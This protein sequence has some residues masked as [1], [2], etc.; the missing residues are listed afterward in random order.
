MEMRDDQTVLKAVHDVTTHDQVVQEEVALE[1]YEVVVIL[2]SAVNDACKKLA[3]EVGVMLED[4][5]GLDEQMTQMSLPA[6][7]VEM[8]E[9]KCRSVTLDT[10][11]HRVC[12]ECVF[13]VCKIVVPR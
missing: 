9:E 8:T 13:T 2:V 3:F 4:V 5:C 12:I 10:L 7:V 1:H 6:R 11:E